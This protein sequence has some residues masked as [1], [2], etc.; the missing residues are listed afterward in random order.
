M[1]KVMYKYVIKDEILNKVYKESD[2]FDDYDEC[3]YY[4]EKNLKTLNNNKFTGDVDFI[5]VDC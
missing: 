3:E 4:M 1:R 5:G 2:L